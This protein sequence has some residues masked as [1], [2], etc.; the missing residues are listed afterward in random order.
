MTFVGRESTMTKNGFNETPAD[1]DCRMAWWR[2]ARFGMFV[3]WGLYSL[4]GGEWK[5]RKSRIYGEWIMSEHLIPDS[6]LSKIAR[7][8]D[9]TG[10]NAKEWVN[11][12]KNA[13]MKYIVITS[14]HHE[15]FCL[16]HSKLT[17]YNI[18]DA[19]PF[20][21][22]IIAELADACRDAGI[23]FGLYY[24]QLD[25]HH[26]LIPGPFGWIP[27]FSKYFDYMKGQLTEL[28]TNYGPIATLFFDGDWML[29]WNRKRGAEIEALCRSLQPYIIINNR[30]GKRPPFS[31]KSWS[32]PFTMN[33]AG[34]DY[35]TPE[36]YV[37]NKI[38]KRDWES[39][40]TINGTFG[41]NKFDDNWKSSR[42]LTRMLIDI[43][44]KGGNFLLNVGPDGR[45]VIP[46]ASIERLNEIGAWLKVNGDAIY[47]V[48]T[49]PLQKLK[50]GR[51]TAK[52]GKIFLHIFDQPRGPLEIRDL[53]A[54]VKKSYLLSDKKK[55]M[56][57][58]ET[59]GNKILITIPD[60]AADPV[61]TTIVL[62][63][64]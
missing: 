17:K 59:S 52:P 55:K 33:T 41:Y 49:G 44:S 4:L 11:I 1:R 37:M 34:G 53:K 62:E 14:K 20:K 56:L 30:V 25:W 36:Q 18:V 46:E 58:L 39:N 2:E 6:T 31:E 63:T 51:S 32:Q 8:F 61:S 42:D 23:R 28:L 12:A 16:F 40:I 5:G 47:G 15:G 54:I 45:G 7:D 57:P 43:A 21:R 48:K 10:F 26:S 13:G 27:D 19:T 29:Q 3:H 24:S 35:E 50:W 38:P 60:I 9:P 22:D 64:T